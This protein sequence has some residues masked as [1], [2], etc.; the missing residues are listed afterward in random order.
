MLRTCLNLTPDK[1]STVSAHTM[2][3]DAEVF[4]LVGMNRR[5]RHFVV[6]QAL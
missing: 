4:G 6:V 3:D 1:V 5:L 2:S